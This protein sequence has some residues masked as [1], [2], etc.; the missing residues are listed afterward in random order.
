MPMPTMQTAQMT[1]QNTV[2]RL[3][4]RST[5]EE[6]A[7]EDETAPPN[8]LDRPPPLPRCS[9][10]RTTS[11]TLVSTSTMLRTS[12]TMTSPAPRTGSTSAAGRRPAS[13][14][15]RRVPAPTDNDDGAGTAQQHPPGAGQRQQ[16]GRR[17]CRRLRGDR[18]R[19]LGG[20]QP[21]PYD[22]VAGRRAGQGERVG[23]GL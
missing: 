2:S 11:S 20:G 3:R 19:R 6:P 23:A 7:S 17:S 10:I 4:L 21:E 18:R 5:T 8:M 9:R 1:P 14:T 13:L 12:S 22:P 15:A 16:R